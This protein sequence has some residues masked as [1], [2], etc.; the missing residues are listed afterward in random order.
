MTGARYFS[1]HNARQRAAGLAEVR[2]R[3]AFP[4]RLGHKC[5]YCGERVA[6][7]L[8]AVNGCA[9]CN[10]T[11]APTCACGGVGCDACEGST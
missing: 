2:A 9:D 5:D 10:A 7:M 4:A 11:T 1:K 8:D 3:K 6:S